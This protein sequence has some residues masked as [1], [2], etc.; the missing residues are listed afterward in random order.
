MNLFDSLISVVRNIQDPDLKYSFFM[1]MICN[2]GL[3]YTSNFA[4]HDRL[5]IEIKTFLLDDEIFQRFKNN[6][7]IYYL[8]YCLE[9]YYNLEMAIDFFSSK[10]TTKN[11]TLQ[12]H[13]S[14]N[15]LIIQKHILHFTDLLQIRNEILDI[16]SSVVNVFKSDEIMRKEMNVIL[17]NLSKNSMVKNPVGPSTMD[18]FILIK[19]ILIKNLGKTSVFNSLPLEEI[20]LSILFNLKENK[21]KLQSV[22]EVNDVE[23]FNKAQTLDEFLSALIELHLIFIWEKKDTHCRVLKS[24]DYLLPK[25][26]NSLTIKLLFEAAEKFK[27]MPAFFKIMEMIFKRLEFVEND[28]AFE[29]L[30]HIK[31]E[32][33]NSEEVIKYFAKK[34]NSKILCKII[35]FI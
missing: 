16:V 8:L 14:L 31:S 21:F 25:N 19:N 6:C 28:K 22:K 5:L 10:Q 9:T 4:I 7:E 2:F 11:K 12:R 34:K 35:A 29:I 24:L 20:L 23:N 3:Y 30:Q 27:T 1:K 18:Y 26:I 33:Q 32:M 17:Q 13:D 15:C